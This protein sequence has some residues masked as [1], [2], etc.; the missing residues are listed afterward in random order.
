MVARDRQTEAPS[1][2]CAGE[3]VVGWGIWCCCHVVLFCVFF[4]LI[5]FCPIQKNPSVSAGLCL[6]PFFSPPGRGKPQEK[7]ETRAANSFLKKTKKKAYFQSQNTPFNPTCRATHCT[8]CDTLSLRSLHMVT[9]RVFCHIP[10]N[11]P[12]SSKLP[13]DFCRQRQG[14]ATLRR[15]SSFTVSSMVR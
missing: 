11:V 15:P 14:H 6:G 13:L 7:D 4:F 3:V 1:V 8:G 5:S 12:G 10:F 9:T 2:G